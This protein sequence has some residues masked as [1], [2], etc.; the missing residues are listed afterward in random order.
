MAFTTLLSG[1]GALGSAIS[2]SGVLTEL[3]GNGYARPAVTLSYDPVAGVIAYSGADFSFTGGST[4]AIVFAVYDASSG[5]NLALYWTV[6]TFT[7]AAGVSLNLP[8]GTVALVKQAATQVTPALLPLEPSGVFQ[9]GNLT[10][11]TTAVYSGAP[12]FALSAAGAWSAVPPLTVLTYAATVTPNAATGGPRFS[13]TLTGNLTLDVPS[14]PV[15]GTEYIFELI[16][17]GT[18][19]RTLTLGTGFKSAGGA[20]TLST[21]ASA[22]DVYRAVY[23][24]TTFLG[25]LSKAYA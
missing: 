6:P 19:S 18:G 16:Q 11:T 5:G 2:A 23:D 22:I 1:Y 4:A 7:M 12:P 25:V 3:S 9:L 14:S 17:D 8:A 24:G 21:A 10:G 20:P 13:V 15:A